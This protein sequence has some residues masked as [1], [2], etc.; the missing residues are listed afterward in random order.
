MSATEHTI[1]IDELID[2]LRSFHAATRNL[3]HK[4]RYTRDKLLDM[5]LEILIGTIFQ[6]KSH[7][8]MA[9]VWNT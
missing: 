8:S 3:I 9:T 2:E 7:I 1:T 6:I 5:S 4:Q